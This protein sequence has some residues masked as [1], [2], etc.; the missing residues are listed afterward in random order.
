VRKYDG[1]YGAVQH[2]SQIFGHH[3][4]T[5]H[6]ISHLVAS[7]ES[8]E[9][10][11]SIVLGNVSGKTRRDVVASRTASVP[12]SQQGLDDHQ[13]K[14]K[15]GGPRSTLKGQSHMRFL[16]GVEADQFVAAG[17]HGGVHDDLGAGLGRSGELAE[18]LLRE[19]HQLSMVHGAGA[20]H[21]KSKKERKGNKIE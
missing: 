13:G 2:F 4:A 15:L 14:S 12:R 3:A 19:V 11:G 1:R 8:H 6:H 20:C 16:H 21:H 7:V 10:V 17:E 9:R 5:K 18:V